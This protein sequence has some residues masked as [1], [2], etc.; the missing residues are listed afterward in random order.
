MTGVQTC[1]LPILNGCKFYLSLCELWWWVKC[2]SLGMILF[3]IWVYVVYVN[4]DLLVA[5]KND[6]KGWRVKNW[7]KNYYFGEKKKLNKKNIKM[8][9][10]KE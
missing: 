7:L 2:A 6:N 8:E 1:A 4:C 3:T 10:G 5:E 9:I